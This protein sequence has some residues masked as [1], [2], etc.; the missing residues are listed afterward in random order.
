MFEFKT[1]IGR[2]LESHCDE[3]GTWRVLFSTNE[4]PVVDQEKM[5]LMQQGMHLAT[6]MCFSIFPD[7]IANTIRHEMK[8]HSLS[9][10]RESTLSGAGWLKN[11]HRPAL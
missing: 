3:D 1:E 7:A 9:V 2:V 5:R 10:V 8:I 4:Q 11:T 6:D